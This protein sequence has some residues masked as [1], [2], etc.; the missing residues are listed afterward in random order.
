MS[1]LYKQIP[2]VDEVLELE[3]IKGMT[4]IP[5]KLILDAIRDELDQIRAEI[6]NSLL[7]IENID[8]RIESIGEN[9]KQRICIFE[10]SHLK[11]VINAT[12]TIIH[13]NLGRSLLSK[14]AAEKL[15]EV[16]YHYSNLEYNLELGQRGSR[17]SHVEKRLCEI[18][19]A[20]AAIVVNNNASA[21]MLVLS[22]MAKN[23]EVIMSRGELVEIGGSF[24]VPDV[25]SQSGAKLIEV[26]TTNKTHLSDYQNAI[27]EETAALMK[28]HTSNY[29]ILGFTASVELEAL[30]ELAHQRGIPAIED[31]GSGVLID[32]AHYGLEHEPTV[33]ESIR[34]GVDVVSFSGDKLLGGPQA[35]IIVGKKEYID[36]MKKNPLTR[37]IRVDKFT[38]SA[39]EE[40]L[41]SYMDEKTAIKEI[42]TLRMITESIELLTQKAEAITNTFTNLDKYM[43]YQIAE[44]Y[45][46]IGGGAMPLTLIPSKVIEIS[47]KTISVNELE[48]KLRK[49]PIPIVARIFQDKLILDV[50]TI[51]EEEEELISGILKQ[52]F[53]EEE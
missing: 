39:L 41:K 13:T 4:D 46:Q 14:K 12:G 26:G 24:R 32:L 20:E 16:A 50:R 9:V 19:G 35:G 42:P 2:K 37:A 47:S 34:A 36:Q 38:V 15:V 43:D 44:G 25:M 45:S 23:R 51:L 11:R 48:S 6:K 21:V 27:T 29:R 10:Q 8:L 5:R 53:E 7:T 1:N 17:Y 22:T 30:V 3:C 18:T 49:Q 52:C 31:I 40:T 33:Q 28:V